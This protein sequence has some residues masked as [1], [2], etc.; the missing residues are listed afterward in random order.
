MTGSWKAKSPNSNDRCAIHETHVKTDLF[1]GKSVSFHI[2][3]KLII[4]NVL[5]TIFFFQ[6]FVK[7][8]IQKERSYFGWFFWHFDKNTFHIANHTTKDLFEIYDQIVGSQKKQYSF[9]DSSAPSHDKLKIVTH[10]K[11]KNKF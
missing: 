8:W 11:V 4:D 1:V 9:F 6:L 3:R 5:E 2:I 10:L 7:K